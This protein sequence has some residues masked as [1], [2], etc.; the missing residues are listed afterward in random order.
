MRRA[1]N[2]CLLVGVIA[3]VALGSLGIGYGARMAAIVLVSALPLA[4]ALWSFAVEA[5]RSGR[6]VAFYLVA[7]LCGVLFLN[8]TG[9]HLTF[10]RRFGSGHGTDAYFVQLGTSGIELALAAVAALGWA[11]CRWQRV[12]T[13][14]A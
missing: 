13:M 3:L 14:P 10:I 9:E 6:R 12:R 11:W 4:A 7:G 8:M 5:D 1:R 2:V